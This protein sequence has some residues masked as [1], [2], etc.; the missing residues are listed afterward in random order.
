MFI[1]T[2][3][4]SLIWVVS[5]HRPTTGWLYICPIHGPFIIQKITTVKPHVFNEPHVQKTP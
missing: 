1:S 4:D 5:P 3:L 2:C